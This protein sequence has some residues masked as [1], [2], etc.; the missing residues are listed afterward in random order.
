MHSNTPQLNLGVWHKRA[1]PHTGSDSPQG[2]RAARD[3]HQPSLPSVPSRPVPARRTHTPH[4]PLHAWHP[5]QTGRTKN[6]PPPSSPSPSTSTSPGSSPVVVAFPFPVP[7]PFYPARVL[8]SPPSPDS[9]SLR[10]ARPIAHRAPSVVGVCRLPSSRF[11]VLRRRRPRCLQAAG[12]GG[13]GL[14]PPPAFAAWEVAPAFT[15]AASFAAC[16][17]TVAERRSIR[18]PAGFFSLLVHDLS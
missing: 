2:S 17:L 14:L 18:A 11:A 4:T 8:H 9:S 3:H 10:S 6:C 1:E 12:C 5:Q 15:F 7:H 16:Y 13:R